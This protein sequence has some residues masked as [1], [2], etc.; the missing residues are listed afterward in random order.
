MDVKTRDL[1]QNTPFARNVDVVA[2][3]LRELSYERKW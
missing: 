1:S 3:A 2:A